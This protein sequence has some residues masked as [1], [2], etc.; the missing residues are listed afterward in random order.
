MTRSTNSTAGGPASPPGPMTMTTTAA[1]WSS[2]KPATTFSAASATC[3]GGGRSLRSV[4]PSRRPEAPPSD[5]A[6]SDDR[7]TKPSSAG[8]AA[9]RSPGSERET[10]VSGSDAVMD[11]A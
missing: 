9:I 3:S 7:G 2:S 8:V 1:G 4:S 10:V 11:R 6:T 5:I